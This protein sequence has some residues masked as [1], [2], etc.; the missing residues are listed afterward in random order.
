MIRI[1]KIGVG[2]TILLIYTVGIICT[3]LT[4]QQNQFPIN[5]ILSFVSGIM[6]TVAIIFYGLE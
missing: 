3:I 6:G 5:M 2:F 4:Y 1:E